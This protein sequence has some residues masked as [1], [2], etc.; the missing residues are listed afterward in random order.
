MYYNASINGGAYKDA[1][2]LADSEI[3][4]NKKALRNNLAQQI[5]HEKMVNMQ[6]NK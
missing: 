4:D 1:T 5:L 2:M 6:Y 3:P